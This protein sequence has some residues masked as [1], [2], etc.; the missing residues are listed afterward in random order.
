MEV[1]P[2]ANGDALAPGGCKFG[3]CPTAWPN[4]FGCILILPS[5]ER[6]D[7]ATGEWGFV[8]ELNEPRYWYSGAVADGSTVVVAGGCVANDCAALTA[9]IE[10]WEDVGAGAEWTFA[11]PLPSPRAFLAAVSVAPDEVLLI[12]GCDFA[13]CSNEVWAVAPSTGALSP[14]SPLP[15]PRGHHKASVL[16]DGRIVVTGGC[17]TPSC[18]EPA[19]DIAI[20]EPSADT[21]TLNGAFLEPRLGASATVLCDDSILVA[22][23]CADALC[24]DVQDTMVLWREGIV[25]PLSSMAGPRHHHIAPRIDDGRVLMFEGCASSTLSK[26]DYCIDESEI[27]LP[28]T[29]SWEAATGVPPLIFGTGRGYHAVTRLT[30]EETL[31]A[32]GC[33]IDVSSPQTLLYANAPVACDQVPPV[34]PVDAGAATDAGPGADAGAAIDAGPPIRPAPACACRMGAAGDEGSSTLALMVFAMAVAGLRR[35]R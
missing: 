30:S 20:Y 12:G 23:G 10:I 22:G 18:D 17:R 3:G 19:Y 25:S 35:R 13:A 14:R 16:S 9:S 29:D 28:S 26:W 21:W 15:A 24:I 2:L 27:Y 33:L 1:Y 6:Y 34:P 11:D 4:D 31:I 32:G 8:D 5:V 7:A